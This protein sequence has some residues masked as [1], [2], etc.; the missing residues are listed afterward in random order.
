MF[1]NVAI[2][3]DHRLVLEGLHNV[4]ATDERMLLCGM[5]ASGHELLEGLKTR[6]P[7]VLLLDLQLP[8]YSGK[9][10]ALEIMKRYPSVRIIILSGIEDSYYIE[11]MMQIGCAGYLLKSSTDHGLLLKAVTSVFYGE[12]FLE[13]TLRKHLLTNIL[14]K[15][16]KADKTASLLTLKEK[17]IMGHI[18]NGLSSQ[19]I[20]KQLGISI[21][22]VEAH[23][24]SLL[25]K[26]EVKNTAELVKVVIEQHLLR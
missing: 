2:T 11:E 9:E 21:R 5:Y 13:E 20:A 12:L 8:D 14:K 1:I 23:R 15:K 4:L 3:D 22:T 19:N 18:M 10:L 16:K 7:D 25:Q 6:Q 24:L 17:E 26:L